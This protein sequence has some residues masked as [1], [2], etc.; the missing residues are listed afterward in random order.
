[1]SS[2]LVGFIIVTA[3][4]SALFFLGADVSNLGSVWSARIAQVLKAISE[5]LPLSDSDVARTRKC[6]IQ[7]GYRDAIAVKYY[8]GAR[9]LC[10]A[11]GFVIVFAILGFEDPPMLLGIAGLCFFL[12][13]FILKQMIRRR[14]KS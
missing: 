1:M 8:S 6:L 13:R 4:A 3:L 14:Q 10:A 2:F 5:A 12:P 7:A 9:L 11:L